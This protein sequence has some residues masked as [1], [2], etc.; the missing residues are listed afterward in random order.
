MQAVQQSATATQAQL[1]D[2]VH[3]LI[4]SELCAALWSMAQHPPNRRALADAGGIPALVE[5]ARLDAEVRRPPPSA[6]FHKRRSWP[7]LTFCQTRRTS[8]ALI[9]LSN[10]AGSFARH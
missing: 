6:L 8:C 3:P 4:Q 9:K 7:P 10:T 2:A 1:A 5:L